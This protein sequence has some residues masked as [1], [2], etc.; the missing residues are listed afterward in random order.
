[1]KWKHIDTGLNTGFFNMNFDLQIAKS[2]PEN[3]AVLRTYRWQ[4]FCISLGANQKKDSID[5]YSANE[6]NIDIVN[7]PTGGRAILHS[8]ELTYSVILPVDSRSSARNIYHEIN[9]ALKKGLTFFDP[10]L[11]TIQ[12]ENIQA[13]FR[14][15]YQETKGI[16]CFA[17]PAKSELKYNGRKVV[18]S[19]QR[20]LDKT[21][22]QHGSIL[23][24]DYHLNIVNYMKISDEEKIKLRNETENST[25][26]LDHILNKE[27]DY[28]LLSE[29]IV[30]GFEKYFNC[31]LE[32]QDQ[33]EFLTKHEV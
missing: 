7:R 2:L 25:A 11:E 20:K 13:D 6:A 33:I 27:I 26:T 24:G 9:M 19:A 5:I 18:G 28:E 22:L 17:V 23:C 12:L 10:K 29:S 32:E 8:E 4:P 30:L 31:K 3:T 16:I 21:I 1:M 15:L 14:S